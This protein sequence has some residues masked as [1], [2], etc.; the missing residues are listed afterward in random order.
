M[1]PTP[2]G[3]GPRPKNK[4]KPN[5]ILTAVKAWAATLPPSH[6]DQADTLALTAPKRWVVYEPMVLLPAGSFT[7]PIWESIL[8]DQQIDPS[9]LWTDILESISRT[10]KSVLTHLAVN[11]GIP[12]QRSGEEENI[13]RSPTG[14]RI[15]H[16]DFGPV[17]TSPVPTEQDFEQAFWVTTRQNGISQTWAPRYTM[18]SRGNVTEKARL[19][20]FHSS[21][22]LVSHRVEGG[23]LRNGWAVDLYGGIGY[24]VFSYAR[25]GLRVLAWEINPWSVEGLRRGAG[26][27]GWEV[28]VVRDT[29]VAGSAGE[30]IFGTDGKG[31]ENRIVVFL[32]DNRHAEGIVRELRLGGR[33]VD[34]VHVNCGL[35]PA[36]TDTW[37]P[38]LR[39]LGE[40]EGWLHLHENVGVGD[41]ESRREEIGGIF[42]GW[43]DVEGGG[44]TA[45]VEHVEKVKTFAPGVWHCVFDVYVSG[46]RGPT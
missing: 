13:L 12:L 27:N 41:I 42:N 37:Q 10:T 5:P 23:R 32:Q 45:E 4:P 1:Q 33:D 17:V 46:G 44:R 14:L 7:N 19:L 3:K 29:Q 9:Q 30:V 34:V 22:S 26:M 6:S 8:N 24:F 28:R 36:S 43:L 25:L 16:G 39:I 15:L 38:A 40:G 18:F 31:E 20:D 35:L 21:Q 2:Q 11:E